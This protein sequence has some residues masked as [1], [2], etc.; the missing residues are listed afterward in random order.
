M[1]EINWDEL[2]FSDM[3]TQ[4][5]SFNFLILVIVNVEIY[6]R[7]TDL[8]KKSGVGVEARG[9]EDWG[10]AFMEPVWLQ[11]ISIFLIVTFIFMYRM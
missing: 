2:N 10:F 3:L 5:H 6:L 1:F 8:F 9:V 4:Q 7:P 11:V